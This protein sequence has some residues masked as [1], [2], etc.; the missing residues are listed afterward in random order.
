MLC[1]VLIGLSISN[2]ISFIKKV[3]NEEMIE[4]KKDSLIAKQYILL[5]SLLTR[6]ILL[7]SIYHYEKLND[8]IIQ[9]ELKQVINDSISVFNFCHQIILKENKFNVRFCK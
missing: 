2:N 8:S 5:D 6:S 3:N 1:V 7:D 9:A 4:L